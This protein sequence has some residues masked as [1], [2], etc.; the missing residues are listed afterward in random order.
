MSYT[1][2]SPLGELSSYWT[3][4]PK[5]DEVY[6]LRMTVSGFPIQRQTDPLQV[7]AAVG[8]SFAQRKLYGLG[9]KCGHDIR[10]I[11]IWTPQQGGVPDQWQLDLICTWNGLGD[12]SPVG[13]GTGATQEQVEADQ[14]IRSA[15][16]QF[17]ITSLN[18][19]QLTGNDT[20]G[21]VAHWLSAPSLWDSSREA[22]TLSFDGGKGVWYGTAEKRQREWKAAEPP[23]IPGCP[24]SP[25]CPDPGGDKKKETDWTLLAV[26]GAAAVGLVAIVAT[27]RS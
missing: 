21:E 15:F 18:W 9:G 26:I 13:C 7:V 4:S 24:G 2:V 3:S 20:Q 5:Q 25:G 22:T 14:K 6:A 19:Y 1:G 17:K 8:R 10:G 23:P 16:P 12:V 27:R 11:V